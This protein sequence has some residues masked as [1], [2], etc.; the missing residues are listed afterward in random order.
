MHQA[1]FCISAS[2]IDFSY[3]MPYKHEPGRGKEGSII[4]ENV[5]ESFGKKFR[6][7]SGERFRKGTDPAKRGRMQCV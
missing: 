6:P 5:I 7:Y 3:T 1:V 2:D 4:Y